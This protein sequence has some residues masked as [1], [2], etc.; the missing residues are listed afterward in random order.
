MPNLRQHVVPVG[1]FRAQANKRRNG[2]LLQEVR[3]EICHLV[4]AHTIGRAKLL[5]SY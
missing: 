1:A 3:E 2:I 4:P 5:E